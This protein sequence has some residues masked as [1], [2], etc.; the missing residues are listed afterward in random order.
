MPTSPRLC[1]RTRHAEVRRRSPER[2]RML[3]TDCHGAVFAMRRS[4]RRDRGRKARKDKDSTLR[5][6][7]LGTKLLAVRRL[8]QYVLH[9]GGL[10][11]RRRSP[12]G[13][14]Q[15]PALVLSL[16]CEK[17]LGFRERPVQK[18]YLSEDK[19]KKEQ[20]DIGVCLS[21]SCTEAFCLAGWKWN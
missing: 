5:P 12:R 15:D 21:L 10:K 4:E 3:R 6:V 11:F 16:L 20:K 19:R 9:A 7:I 18:W 17:E 2:R 14:T 8:L 13:M 1:T